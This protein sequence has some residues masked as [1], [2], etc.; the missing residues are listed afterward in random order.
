MVCLKYIQ[1]CSVGVGSCSFDPSSKDV[2]L[3]T[4]A[5]DTRK[6]PLRL[7]KKILKKSHNASRAAKM[8]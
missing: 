3:H 2:V 8:I 6:T 5:S 7:V 4:F 1:L